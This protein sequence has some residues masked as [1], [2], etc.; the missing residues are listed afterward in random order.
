MEL[1]EIATRMGLATGAGLLLGLDRELRGISAGIRTHALVAMSSALIMISSL[2]L[3]AEL[4]GETGATI[5]PLRSI[6]GLA[7]AIGFVAAGAVFVSKSS[8]HNLT[9][10]ANLWLAAALGIAAGAGQYRL[11]LVGLVLGLVIVTLVRVLARFIP[12]SAKI[13]ED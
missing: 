5:D 1:E 12:G 8:V 7:Q 10:A 11:V 4:R 3:F 13:H 6:Q 2:M 9:S